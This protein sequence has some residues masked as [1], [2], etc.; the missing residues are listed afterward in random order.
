MS[1]T[2]IPVSSRYFSLT[3][4]SAVAKKSCLSIRLQYPGDGV[5]VEKHKRLVFSQIES[6]PA[7]GENLQITRFGHPALRWDQDRDK[8]VAEAQP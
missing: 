7:V 6:P 2:F 1:P 5:S 3:R 4:K 8:T